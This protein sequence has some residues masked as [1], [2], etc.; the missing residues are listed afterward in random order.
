MEQSPLSNTKWKLFP[1]KFSF[2]PMSAG[3]PYCLLGPVLRIVPCRQASPCLGTC[4]PNCTVQTGP[5]SWLGACP[6]NCTVQ[7]GLFFW[8]GD[9]PR[10][11]TVQA[12]SLPRL[13]VSSRL[14]AVTN[15]DVSNMI[16]EWLWYPLNILFVLLNNVGTITKQIPI[17]QQA[18]LEIWQLEFPS[19]RSG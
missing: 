19:W 17:Y 16:M 11:C 5:F 18:S 10:N 9:C 4:P 14:P 13:L 6:R 3:E 7:A 12:S 15:R 1:G 8:L 2:P